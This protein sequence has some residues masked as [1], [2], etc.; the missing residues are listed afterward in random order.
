M[1]ARWWEHSAPHSA[2]GTVTGLARCVQRHRRVASALRVDFVVAEIDR[3][4]GLWDAWLVPDVTVALGVEEDCVLDV[5]VSA[6]AEVLGVGLDACDVV[7]EVV[8]SED[9]VKHH[10]DVMADLVVGV[11]VERTVT[12]HQI[13]RDYDAMLQK[14]DVVVQVVYV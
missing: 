8:A 3:V 14:L 11:D 13:A 1:P 6:T 2:S 4:L 7:A 12:A 5:A 9:A 10:L